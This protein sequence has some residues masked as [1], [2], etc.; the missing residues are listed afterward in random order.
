MMKGQCLKHQLGYLSTV[1]IWPTFT[2][3][4]LNFCVSLSQWRGTTVSFENHLSSSFFFY[5]LHKTTREHNFSLLELFPTT[6]ES[7]PLT[8][9]DLSFSTE[10]PSSLWLKWLAGKRGY[11]S[12]IGLKCICSFCCNHYWFTI[13]S[14]NSV[15]CVY[16]TVNKIITCFIT[17]TFFKLMR[18]KLTQKKRL[19]F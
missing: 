15:L 11:D 17:K 3:L 2:W 19:A 5:F 6:L 4:I 10:I 14:Q 8:C 9:L 1:E 18:L 7:T 12:P 13:T 16:I